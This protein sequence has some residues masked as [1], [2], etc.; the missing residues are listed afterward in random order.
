MIVLSIFV[1]L[2]FLSHASYSFTKLP[3]KFLTL[4]VMHVNVIQGICCVLFNLT[5]NLQFQFPVKSFIFYGKRRKNRTDFMYLARCSSFRYLP[6]GYIRRIFY[7]RMKY[8]PL[9]FSSVNW[10]K[11]GVFTLNMMALHHKKSQTISNNK[12]TK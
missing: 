12:N 1:Q 10:C 2:L 5:C 9:A 6:R 3:I 11:I 7:P 4:K 8:P